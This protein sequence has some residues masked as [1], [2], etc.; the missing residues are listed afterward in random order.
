MATRRDKRRSSLEWIDMVIIKRIG[1][2][3]R[4]ISFRVHTYEPSLKYKKQKNIKP[5]TIK[6]NLSPP[7]SPDKKKQS[8]FLS[9]STLTRVPRP[10]LFGTLSPISRVNCV[11]YCFSKRCPSRCPSPTQIRINRKPLS[12]PDVDRPPPQI[13]PSPIKSSRGSLTVKPAASILLSSVN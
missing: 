8:I 3:G 10:P 12:R 13:R 9:Y 4:V 6:R 1:H 2:L 11:A 5:I 7:T